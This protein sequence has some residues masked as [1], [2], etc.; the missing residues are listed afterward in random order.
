MDIELAINSDKLVFIE[1]Y[2]WKQKQVIRK[3][4]NSDVLNFDFGD[5]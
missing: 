3:N 4:I 5:S 2:G 1:V